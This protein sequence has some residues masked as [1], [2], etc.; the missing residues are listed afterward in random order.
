MLLFTK[1]AANAAKAAS[2]IRMTGFRRIRPR[3][4]FLLPARFATFR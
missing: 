4:A 3:S 2:G 1:N